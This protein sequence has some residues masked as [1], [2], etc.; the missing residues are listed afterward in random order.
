MTYGGSLAHYSTQR[1]LKMLAWCRRSRF[2]N[3][4]DEEYGWDPYDAVGI[5]GPTIPVADIKTELAGR[6][7][8]PNKAEQRAIRQAKAKQRH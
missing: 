8:V 6:E 1:L 2:Y 4:H 3:P 5:S 7:H